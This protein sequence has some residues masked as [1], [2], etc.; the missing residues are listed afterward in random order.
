MNEDSKT[1]HVITNRDIYTLVK[2]MDE[3]LSKQR[4]TLRWHTWAITFITGILGA[5]IVVV[6]TRI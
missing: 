4:A 2:G 6:G 5:L 1:F 3:K